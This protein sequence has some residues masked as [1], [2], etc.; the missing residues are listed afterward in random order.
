MAMKNSAV[1]VVDPVL[2]TIV[3]GY[4]NPK[5]VGLDLFP[6][7]PVQIS[8]GQVIEFGPDAMR[9]YNTKRVPGSK[10]A[11]IQPGYLGKPY[12][13]LQDSLEIPVPREHLRDAQLVPNIDL[14]SRSISVAM[15]NVTLALEVDQATI[16]TNAANYAATNKVTLAGATKWSAA[17]GT[18]LDD[19]DAAK[20][21]IRTQFGVYPNVLVLSAKAFNAAKNNPTVVA[22]LQY[23]AQVSPDAT[24]I[25]PVMLAGL[26]GV[27]KVVVGGGIY[28]SDAN[29]STDIWGN[30][31]VLAYVPPVAVG[32][33]EPSYGYT[34]TMEGNPFVEAPYYDQ[35]AKS[36]IYGATYERAPVLS[37]MGGGYLIINPA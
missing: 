29:V 6:A 21:A 12:A 36:W 23:N 1:R 7:V 26:F 24:Q 17:T 5:F 9:L 31:A 8:G 15:S 30:N 34:Y 28:F 33:E 27:D 19:I 37:G 18:P 16:A 22:R 11:R 3:Q 25:T 20:E 4:R 35:S 32:M 2:S 13:L 10:T 14:A